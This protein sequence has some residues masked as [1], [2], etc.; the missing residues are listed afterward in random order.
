MPSFTSRSTASC[1]Y[2]ENSVA[3]SL[4]HLWSLKQVEPLTYQI[5]AHQ[6]FAC[7]NWHNRRAPRPPARKTQKSG[8]PKANH[9]PSR[10]AVSSEKSTTRRLKFLTSKSSS[11]SM[12][13]LDGLVVHRSTWLENLVVI[14][15][16]TRL[17]APPGFLASPSRAGGLSMR[18]PCAET[19][20]LTSSNI[21]RWHH[22]ST[23]AATQAR[24]CQQKPHQP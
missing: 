16:R 18:L 11:W 22:H 7:W 14:R 3:A 19:L 15:R 6:A 1:S 21:T 24:P 5:C 8:Q 12:R 23:L 20:L 4:L 13:R 10:A 17:H 9:A 2:H